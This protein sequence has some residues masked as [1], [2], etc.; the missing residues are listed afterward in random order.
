LDTAD[1]R[2]LLG[3]FF[4]D[5]CL[6]CKRGPAS[7]YVKGSLSAGVHER[8]F[9][10]EKV[11]EVR[12]FIPTEAQIVPYQTR[13]RDTGSRTTVLRFR[14][15]S[16]KLRPVY[17]LLYPYRQRKVTRAVLELL[18]GRAAAWL[19]AEGIRPGRS[20]YVLRRV[21]STTNEARMI[22]GWMELLTG[23]ASEVL[24]D[25]SKPRLFFSR[26]QAAQ[27]R[28]ALR[29]YAPATRQSLFEP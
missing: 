18:G 9:L 12:L 2:G 14:V 4:A 8:D 7:N 22:S 20:G 3:L 29:P 11:A 27:A 10:E 24:S 17:N 6:T 15:A 13:E 26:D 25:H 16:T 1:V 19:W 21:G 23:A 28:A 5:G